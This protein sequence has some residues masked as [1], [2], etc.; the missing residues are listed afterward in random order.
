MTMQKTENI[1]PGLVRRKLQEVLPDGLLVNRNWLKKQ[2]F[3]RPQVDYYL[4]SGMLVATARGVYRRAGPP[5]KWQ[6]VLYSLQELGFAVHVGGRAALDHQGLAHYLPM[7][8]QQ[9]IQLYSDGGMPGWLHEVETNAVF[10]V[11]RRSLFTRSEVSLGL[12]T[13]PFGGWDWPLNY[14]TRERALLE[15]LDELP[16]KADLDMAD[17]YMESATNLRPKLLMSLLQACSRVK[18]K[19]LFLWLAERY[20]PAWFDKLDIAALDLGSGKRVIFKSGVLNNKY[21]ITVPRRFEQGDD[22]GGPKQPLF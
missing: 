16:D 8:A 20:H 6:H 3:N 15:Y 10:E 14:A 19:R 5:L 13:L 12:T 1:N 17:K 22:S 18:T 9:T 7:G 11:H 21:N 4:R 2:G